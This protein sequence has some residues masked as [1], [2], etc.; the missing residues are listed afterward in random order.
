MRKT[1]PIHF[2]I[3]AAVAGAGAGHGQLRPTLD[4]YCVDCHSDAQRTAGLSLESV[5]A[6]DVAAAPETW[7]K[8]ARKL[9]AG[10]M[11]PAGRSRP[12][13]EATSR[14]LS[15]LESELDRAAAADPRPG[16]P[17]IHRLNRTEYANAIRDL[18]ALEVDT[19]S[20]LPADDLAFGFDN[21]ADTLSFSPLLL[22]RYLATARKVS[23]LA[24]GDPS[25]R[26]EVETHHAAKVLVQSDRMSE[27][28]PFGSRGGLAI[29]H[30]FPLDA[31]YTFKVALG[32]RRAGAETL[33]IR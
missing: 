29:R 9:R 24:V 17:A 14:L 30:R 31:H 2:L 22:E 28:L 10:A 19:R 21:I 20:L 16:R 32:G 7:E 33:E 11:P 6:D 18:L 12:S 3:L 25:L 13:G 8:V 5:D 23:R 26:P 15:G 4:R 27:E 1:L